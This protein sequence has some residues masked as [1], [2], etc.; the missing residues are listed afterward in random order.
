MTDFI[1]LIYLKRREESIFYCLN[2]FIYIRKTTN[3]LTYSYMSELNLGL[4]LIKI[5]MIILGGCFDC[6]VAER[7]EC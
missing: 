1:I 4:L 7:G 6:I 3:D 5:T 2:Y